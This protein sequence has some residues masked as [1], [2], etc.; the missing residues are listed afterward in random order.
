MFF[1]FQQRLESFWVFISKSLLFTKKFIWDS[2]SQQLHQSH[3]SITSNFS[4]RRHWPPISF[5][6][7]GQGDPTI[8]IVWVAGSW[9]D[10]EFC[11]TE[12]EFFEKLQLTLDSTLRWFIHHYSLVLQRN[13][14]LLFVS[15]KR[16]H[17][18]V[19]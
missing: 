5:R 14:P 6:V 3:H 18:R 7:L 1:L 12:N 11:D 4:C 16:F 2:Q 17:Q 15:S 19:Q 10:V 8:K 9:N 13:F